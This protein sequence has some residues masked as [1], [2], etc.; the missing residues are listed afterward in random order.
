MNLPLLDDRRTLLYLFIGLRLMLALVYQPYLIGGVERGLSAAGDH[1]YFFSLF[2][3]SAQGKLPYRDYWYEFPPIFPLIGQVV[4]AIASLRGAPDFSAFATILGLLMTAFDVGNLLLIMRI[5]ARVHDRAVGMALGWIYALLAAPLVFSWWGFEPLV[6]FWI[7]LSIAFLIERSDVPS[8]L[9]A[10]LGALT[11]LFPLIIL[12]AVVRF[13]HIRAAARYAA[14]AFGVT[15][16]GL[17]GLLVFAGSTTGSFGGQFGG[18]S[19]VAQWNK[20]SYETIWALL[21]GNYRTGRFGEIS[22]HFDPAKALDISGALGGHPPVIAAWLRLLIFGAIGLAVFARTRRFDDLGIVAFTAITIT[23]FFLWAGGWSPQWQMSLIPLM[24]LT[25]PNRTGVLCALA[26]GLVSFY[27]Y[28]V[29]FGRTGDTGG[30]ISAAQL[31]LYT[32]LIVTRTG[33]LIGFAAAL[34]GQL[35]IPVAADKNGP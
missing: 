23:L 31:P 9:V 25:L 28:P 29:L 3:L 2:S 5:G 12:G 24:L 35:R 22:N 4:F 30:V 21:D 7:L 6:T 11:K 14:I 27:E 19:L 10:A 18:A 15:A 33:I 13:R 26:L 32:A 17:I 16:L 20:P 34:Y 1:S 8:A